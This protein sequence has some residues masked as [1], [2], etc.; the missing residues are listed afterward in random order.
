M[1]T[2]LQK[3]YRGFSYQ[4]DYNSLESF[5]NDMKRE[6]EGND[7]ICWAHLFNESG[8]R[9]AEYKRGYTM[10]QYLEIK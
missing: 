5:N 4:K 10:A 8:D 3:H 2:S 9:V 1:F 7:E 6:H